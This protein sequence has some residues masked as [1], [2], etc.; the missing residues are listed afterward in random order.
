L[1]CAF[2]V[3]VK[4]SAD[5]DV[6]AI[7]NEVCRGRWAVKCGALAMRLRSLEGRMPGTSVAR[8]LLALMG[9]PRRWV[10]RKLGVEDFHFPGTAQLLDLVSEWPTIVHCFN[11]HGGY[12]DLRHLSRLSRQL[13]VIL[14]LCDAWLLSG[15]CAHSFECERW[16]SGCGRCP[17]LSIYPAIARD[18]TRYNW[19]RKRAIFAK[20]R[21]FVAAPSR[22]LMN[23]VEQ[24]VLFRAV[25][26]SRVIPTGID[27]ATFHMA[28][29][30]AARSEL[31]LPRSARV[32]LFTANQVRTNIFKDYAT[33]EASIRIL[34][35]GRH[36][37][38]VLL[39][40]GDDAPS[41]KEIGS[42]KMRFVQKLCDPKAV[43]RFYQAADLYVHAAKADTLPR[44]VLEALACGTPV[45]ASAV[46]G[47]P[48]AVND[49]DHRP[50]HEATGIL[51]PQGDPRAL[52]AGIQRLLDDDGLRQRVAESAAQDARR[53]FDLNQQVN[54]YLDW[55]RDLL[56][57][58]GAEP[59][60]G[61]WA[62]TR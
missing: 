1:S 29:K 54:S 39:A 8:E 21:L 26:E 18:A 3:G 23:K 60:M 62:P 48:E 53:R 52:A 31:G 11:L 7:P 38:T 16:K 27:L 32:L 28:D 43:A 59:P 10:D 13:P 46:G 6:V 17:D 25:V 36:A 9:E 35:E 19:S 47:I 24:S 51:V 40:L 30:L 37:S 14:D 5:P 12:F 61:P 41:E 15:H 49:L 57:R 34:A 22:W 4:G 55:Y 20:S 33:L 45:V 56:E 44:T 58:G 50:V 42:V 2:A